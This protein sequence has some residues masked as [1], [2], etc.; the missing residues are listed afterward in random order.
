MSDRMGNDGMNEETGKETSAGGRG[1]IHLY[2]GDGKGKTTAAAGLALRSLGCGK[3]VLFVQLLKNGQSSETEPLRQLGADVR[4][5]GPE[6]P[7]VC[8]MTPAERETA[9]AECAALLEDA[10]AER[11][12]VLVL[13]ELCI[14]RNGGFVSEAL[15][16]RAV[17]E[18]PE[19]QELVMTGRDP[20]EWMVRAAD[21]IT[22]MKCVR[23]PYESGVR[24][25]KGT[26]Y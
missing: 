15:A 20:E 1:L 25:R 23:H 26:E 16:K 14:A 10:I 8:R 19:E 7:L 9:A 21:Y 17:L 2:C 6:T 18:K 13:D 12:D 5:C 24:A 22:E 4:S 3:K 11:P